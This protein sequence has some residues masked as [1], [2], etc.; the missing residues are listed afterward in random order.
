MTLS[1]LHLALLFHLILQVS[2]TCVQFGASAFNY[3]EVLRQP[4]A[5]PT[6]GQKIQMGRK[7]SVTKREDK[8]PA[9]C[10]SPSVKVRGSRS[11]QQGRLWMVLHL[12]KGACFGTPHLSPSSL[13][14]LVFPTWQG[15]LWSF[16]GSDGFGTRASLLEGLWTPN[17]AQNT[18][19]S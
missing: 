6:T 8:P 15:C 7:G 16:C 12:E 4:P 18:P 10:P 3:L 5:E 11:W 14:T 1:T 19:G 9:H 13:G 17:P 2:F